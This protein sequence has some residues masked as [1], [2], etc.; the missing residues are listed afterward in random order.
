[1]RRGLDK[2][3]NEETTTQVEDKLSSS[4]ISAQILHKLDTSLKFSRSERIQNPKGVTVQ[5]NE[6]MTRSLF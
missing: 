6:Q 4:L 5:V 2:L 3:I 1:M